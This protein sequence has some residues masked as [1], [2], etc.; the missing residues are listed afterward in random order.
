[1][2]KRLSS[3]DL[4][5]AAVLKLDPRNGERQNVLAFVESCYG[6]LVRKYDL[7]AAINALAGL[8]EDEQHALIVWALLRAERPV[9]AAS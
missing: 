1:M 5:I 8:S 2:G 7:P 3:V 9:R 6:G 4:L